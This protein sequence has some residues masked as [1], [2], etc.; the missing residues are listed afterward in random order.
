MTVIAGPMPKKQHE[1]RRQVR[2]AAA[3]SSSVEGLELRDDSSSP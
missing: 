2:D 1:Q 3:R